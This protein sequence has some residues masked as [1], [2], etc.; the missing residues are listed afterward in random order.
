MEQL[1]KY[2]LKLKI[3]LLFELW[4]KLFFKFFIAG[5]IMMIVFA[6]ISKWNYLC[7][8]KLFFIIVLAVVL[9]CSFAMTYFKRITWQKTAEQADKLGYEERFITALELLEKNTVLNNMEQLAVKDAFQKAN[10]CELHKKYQLTLPKKQIQILVLLFAVLFGTSFITTTQQKEAERYSFAQL[11][12]IEEVKKE[13]DREKEFD[14]DVLKAFDKEMNSIAKNLKRAQ[15]LEESKKLVEEAQQAIKALEKDS[16][17]EDLKK[18]AEKLS[19][20][21]KTKELANALEQ[22]DTQQINNQM[23]KLL[24]QMENMSQQELEQIAQAMND[25]GKEL[26]DEELKELLENLSEQLSKG[27]LAQANIKGQALKGKLAT[28]SLSLI[29]I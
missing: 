20:S 19:Q 29:H 17:P 7:D 18:T 23:D 5:T 28:L 4:Y 11:K 24:S 1:K 9:L 2:L 25:M 16:I 27:N 14:E 26:S 22:G 10:E 13:I 12:K 21:E 3:K 15:T 8:S 6:V